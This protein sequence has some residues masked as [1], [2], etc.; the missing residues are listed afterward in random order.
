MEMLNGFHH[1]LAAVIKRTFRN[2][3]MYLIAAEPV[4]SNCVFDL[5][6]NI[7]GL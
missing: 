7:A 3:K 1:G 2:L 6:V 5:L 4:T